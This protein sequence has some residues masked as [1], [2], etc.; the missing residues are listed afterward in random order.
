[1]S[2]ARIK[3]LRDDAASWAERLQLD[4]L[5]YETL[6]PPLTAAQRLD[7][8]HRDT[9]G[10]APQPY[11]RLAQTYRTLGLDSEGR[12]VLLAK[13]R[14]RR[15][16]QSLPARSSDGSRTSWSATAT[17]RSARRAGWWPARLR[18]VVFSLE[19]PPS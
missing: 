12:S 13:A 17:A 6:D 19:H 7:W 2:Y 11:E 4:G 15:A 18:D 9:D 3:L 14:D 5:Q 8:L 16:T 1:M 10:Y